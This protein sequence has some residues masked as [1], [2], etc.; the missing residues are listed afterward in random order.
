M[1]STSL[2][3]AATTSHI[4]SNPKLKDDPIHQGIPGTGIKDDK[5]SIHDEKVQ[6]L[7]NRHL[8]ML[9]VTQN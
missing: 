5:S 8:S 3:N 6:P 4:S 7:F 2:D 9:M 1:A